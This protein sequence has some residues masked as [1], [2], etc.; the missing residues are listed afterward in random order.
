MQPPT[1]FAVED[2][3]H[4]DYVRHRL[5]PNPGDL[6]YLHLSDLLMALQ[7]DASNE[8]IKIL[9]FG[10]GGSPYRSLFPVADYRRADIPGI[11]ALDYLIGDD[12]CVNAPNETFDLVLSTQVVEHVPTPATYFSECYRVLRNGGTLIISTH[13]MFEEHGCPFDFHRWTLNGLRRDLVSAGFVVKKAAKLTT[14]ARCGHFLLDAGATRVDADKNVIS[15]LFAATRVLRKL[16]RKTMH[17]LLDSNFP[18]L[19]IVADDRDD[20]DRHSWYV[21]VY[22]VACKGEL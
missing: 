22:V 2:I 11:Q 1:S 8:P 9:D 5:S 20:V 21:G 14:G 6:L 15:W 16:F 17:R 3:T 13:G 4:E 12:D 18:H 10:A 19:R 7:S